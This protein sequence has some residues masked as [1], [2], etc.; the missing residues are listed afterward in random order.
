MALISLNLAI[1]NA[2]PFP[3]SDGGKVFFLLLEGIRKKPL[4]EKTEMRIAG[5]FFFF[6][7]GIMVLVTIKDLFKLF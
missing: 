1:F 4:N 3:V 2:L 5:V 6:L 7:L